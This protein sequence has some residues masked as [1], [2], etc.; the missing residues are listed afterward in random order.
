MG[1]PSIPILKTIEI[2]VNPNGIVI[3]TLNRPERANAI[4]SELMQVK[5]NNRIN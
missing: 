2:E 1:E 5:A 3:L 4:D